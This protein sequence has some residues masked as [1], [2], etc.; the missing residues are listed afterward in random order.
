[1]AINEIRIRVSD[2]T[3]RVM[4]R[5]GGASDGTPYYVGARAYVTQLSNGAEITVIDKE[6]TTTAMV[7][8]GVSPTATVTK[9]GN[10]ATVTVTDRNG[11]TVT[12]IYDGAGVQLVRW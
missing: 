9:S 8:D 2:N 6:G 5:N 4:L 12:N 1:M 10:N 11:T 3:E 7:D